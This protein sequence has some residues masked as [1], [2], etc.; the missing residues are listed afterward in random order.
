MVISRDSRRDDDEDIL[1][2]V[3]SGSGAPAT[4]VL[5]AHDGEEAL[6]LA[7]EHEPDL[8]VLDVM[9]PKMDGLRSR[10]PPAR[11][12]GDKSIPIIMLTARAQDTD[13]QGASRPAPTTTC[14]SRSARR[15]CGRGCRRCWHGR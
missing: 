14:A 2:L 10:P 11:G 3:S 7:L 6:A 5:Q 13:V 8:A 9:M 15:S 1:Q 12:G 4:R